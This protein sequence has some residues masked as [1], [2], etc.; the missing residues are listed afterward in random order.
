MFVDLCDFI[1]KLKTNSTSSPEDMETLHEQRATIIPSKHG[2]FSMEEV[3]HHADPGSCWI[4]IK[5]GVYDVTNF[6]SEVCD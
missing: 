4:V 1:F 5:D 3:S 2:V 6:L